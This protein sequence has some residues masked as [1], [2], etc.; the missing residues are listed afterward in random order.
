MSAPVIGQ[1]S[2]VGQEGGCV[3]EW[4][5]LLDQG[6]A[7]VAVDG[8]PT[9]REDRTWITLGVQEAKTDLTRCANQVIAY[10]A[11]Q[12]NDATAD[13]DRD[14]FG[15]R[16]LTRIRRAKRLGSDATEKRINVRLALFASREVGDLV[17]AKLRAGRDECWAVVERWLAGEATEAECAEVDARVRKGYRAA[18]RVAAVGVDAD[19]D[20]AA[21]WAAVRAAAA[22]A[23]VAAAADAAAAVAVAAAAAASAARAAAA[24]VDAG[25]DAAAS[26]ARAARQ[27]WLD[28]LLDAHEKAVAEEGAYDELLEL[29]EADA[30]AF[31]EGEAGVSS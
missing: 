19:A 15:R 4:V 21:D 16:F 24:G 31:A 20:A 29:W 8:L 10:A 7:Q 9:L 3:M 22:S 28:R 1:G 26:A 23:A 13:E 11:Q 2:H 14:E 30:C 18:V 27:D 25:V 17:P 12:A 5:A 6:H